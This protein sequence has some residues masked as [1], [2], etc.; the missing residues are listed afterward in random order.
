MTELAAS[1]QNPSRA[2]AIC[3]KIHELIDSVG[4]FVY[5]FFYFTETIP[6]I[7]V[8]FDLLLC[9]YMYIIIFYFKIMFI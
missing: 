8:D 9:M 2:A 5:Y 4:N 6:P 1:L 7:C 3:G